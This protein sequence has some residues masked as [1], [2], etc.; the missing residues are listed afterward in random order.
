MSTG[1]EE[2]RHLPRTAITAAC[3]VEEINEGNTASAIP[4]SVLQLSPFS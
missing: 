2:W 3:V 1:R 4:V